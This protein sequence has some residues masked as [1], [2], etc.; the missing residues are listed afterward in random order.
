MYINAQEIKNI[1]KI[2][3]KMPDNC[4]KKR[5]RERLLRIFKS[6]VF[7]YIIWKYIEKWKKTEVITIITVILI[8]CD[9]LDIYIYNITIYRYLK[10]Y[11]EVL[12]IYLK[13]YLYFLSERAHN[14]E[15][16]SRRC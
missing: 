13:H 14:L 7:Q 1:I 11:K 15:I 9:I 16:Y 12:S 10:Y 8:M 6:I 5:E 4:F 2:I 3:I